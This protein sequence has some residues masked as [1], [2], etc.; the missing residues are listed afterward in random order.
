MILQVSTGGRSGAGHERGG[1]L[2]L[3]PEMAS[4]ATGSCNFP[5]QGL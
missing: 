5:D 3:G 4:L 1:M 2:N